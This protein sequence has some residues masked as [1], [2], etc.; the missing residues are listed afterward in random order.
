MHPERGRKLRPCLDR[1]LFSRS[2]RG[3]SARMARMESVLKRTQKPDHAEAVHSAA[4]AV[5]PLLS[6]RQGAIA[7]G[8]KEVVNREKVVGGL[9]MGFENM[10]VLL[11]RT[12]AAFAPIMP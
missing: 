8:S 5:T 4:A 7:R 2:S 1:E 10:I 11:G 9:R 12:P 6:Y 3:K